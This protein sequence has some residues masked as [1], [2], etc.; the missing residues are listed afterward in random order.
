MCKK[1]SSK[2]YI[3]ETARLLVV[4]FETGKAYPVLIRA[5]ADYTADMY[6]VTP[7]KK[8]RI[9]DFRYKDLKGQSALVLAIKKAIKNKEPYVSSFICRRRAW[10]TDDENAPIFYSACESKD[11]QMLYVYDDT[12]VIT[13]AERLERLARKRLASKHHHDEDPTTLKKLLSTKDVHPVLKHIHYASIPVNIDTFSYYGILDAGIKA[14]K[15]NPDLFGNITHTFDHPSY[16]SGKPDDSAYIYKNGVRTGHDY[17]DFSSA[18]Y[19]R[20]YT[21]VR[22][23][24]DFSIR[25]YFDFKKNNPMSSPSEGPE[26]IFNTLMQEGCSLMI[27]NIAAGLWK[28]EAFCGAGLLVCLAELLFRTEALKHV[29]FNPDRMKSVLIQFNKALRNFDSKIQAG[30]IQMVLR[31]YWR[32]YTNEDRAFYPAT[33]TYKD[34]KGLDKNSKE[35][36]DMVACNRE[37]RKAYKQAHDI[38]CR[39]T[40]GFFEKQEKK[41]QAIADAV[42]KDKKSYNAVAKELKVSKKTIVAILKKH[43]AQ[44]AQD[45]IKKAVDLLAFETYDREFSID[46]KDY[47]TWKEQISLIKHGIVYDYLEFKAKE[48][49][50]ESSYAPAECRDYSKSKGLKLNKNMSVDEEHTLY[51]SCK[52]AIDNVF[53]V[54]GQYLDRPF[55]LQGM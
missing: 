9:I 25:L 13:E 39:H 47:M 15:S 49:R 23:N 55:I 11:L 20:E 19:Y 48:H 40:V 50:N 10:Q 12:P 1:S 31:N 42:L 35:Y 33:Y 17:I 54:I 41:A 3:L 26:I 4:Y 6:S 43:I 30:N 37:Y 7:V 5:Y 45:K 44:Q 29:D 34:V 38:S 22:E 28:P 8:S 2:G 14:Q 52:G 27:N 46:D 51:E 21:D 32:Q 36:R 18:L 16:K 53:S 24:I